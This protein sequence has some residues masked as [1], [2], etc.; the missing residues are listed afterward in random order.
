MNS[1]LLKPFDK[2][3]ISA[4]RKDLLQTL[5]IAKNIDRYYQDAN[6]NLDFYMDKFKSL[7]DMFNKKYKGI[8]IR[9]IKKTSEIELK[10]F[11]NEKN[12]QEC[13]ANSASKVIGVQSIGKLTPTVVVSDTEAFANKLE[14]AKDKLHLTY[15]NPDTGKSTVFLHY[16]KKEKKIELVYGMEEIVNE[17]SPEFQIAAYY[18][19]AQGYNNKINLHNEGAVLGFSFVPYHAEKAEI[20][21][22]FDPDIGE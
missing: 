6:S 4:F 1:P 5:R 3:A 13:F 21:R 12:V 17:P 15:Y 8:K 19:L 16:D 2:K 20:L 7:V 10:I 11:L 22:K 18:A 9:P 14:K